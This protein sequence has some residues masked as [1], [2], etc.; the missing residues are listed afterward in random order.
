MEHTEKISKVTEE[1]HS[2]IGYL[3][4]EYDLT[5]SDLVGILELL[6]YSC[7]KENYEDGD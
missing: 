5:V 7:I 6:K 2:K 1:I 3:V 4:Q